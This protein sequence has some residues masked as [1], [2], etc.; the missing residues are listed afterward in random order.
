M[1]VKK[2]NALTFIFITI[3]IDVIGLGIII[4]VMPNLI[5]EL[6]GEGLSKASFY[7]GLLTFS[8]G[9]MQFLF[10]PL[11]GALSDRY[12]RRPILLVALLGLG[13]DYIFM[14]CAPTIAWLFVGRVLAGICGASFYK[15]T[16]LFFFIQ[17]PSKKKKKNF[18]I[19]C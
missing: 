19:L 8:Y 6:T 1:T 10:S 14:A 4:P 17:P 13:C 12:G 7:S 15:H 2:T 9:T 5:K 3:L 16:N 11:L 18:F